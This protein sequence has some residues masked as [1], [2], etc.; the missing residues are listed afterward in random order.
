LGTKLHGAA[1]FTLLLGDACFAGLEGIDMV[2]N[3]STLD[4]IWLLTG[5]GDGQVLVAFG[6][7]LLS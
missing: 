5:I 3:W 6:L 1:F 4:G 7:V 2:L